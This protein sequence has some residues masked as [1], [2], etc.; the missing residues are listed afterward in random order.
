MDLKVGSGFKNLSTVTIQC[1]AFEWLFKLLGPFDIGSSFQIQGTTEY[2]TSPVFECS[3]C[4]RMSNGPIIECH[5][6]TGQI[7]PVFEWFQL[8][9]TVL[10]IKGN[11]KNIFCIKQSVFKW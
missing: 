11:K 5:S 7:L 8:A 10:L 2:L 1:P 4:V 3:I 6:K 9:Q